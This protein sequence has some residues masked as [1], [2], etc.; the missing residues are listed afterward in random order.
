MGAILLGGFYP[1]Q[2][3]TLDRA[4][5]LQ[6]AFGMRGHL[7]QRSAPGRHTWTEVENDGPLIGTLEK[8]S[9]WKN[10]SRHIYVSMNRIRIYNVYYNNKLNNIYKYQP[11]IINQIYLH[12]LSWFHLFQF[13]EPKKERTILTRRSTPASFIMFFTCGRQPPSRKMLPSPLRKLHWHLSDLAA[14]T[15]GSKQANFHAIP[16]MPIRNWCPKCDRNS[17]TPNNF[18]FRKTGVQV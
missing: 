11:I 6:L 13:L 2:H 10:V 12:V 7:E 17:S 15:M 1:H 18:T 3:A 5:E 16:A 4:P 14:K 8:W 9:C